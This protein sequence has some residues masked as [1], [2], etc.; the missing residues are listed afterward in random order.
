MEK[1]IRTAIQEL[2]A[3]KTAPVMFFMGSETFFLDEAIQIIENNILTEDEKAFNQNVVY[4]PEANVEM[5]ISIARS[6]PMMAQKR[7]LILKEAQSF[8][9][10]EKL[11]PYFKNPVESTIF[12]ILYRGKKLDKKK[13]FTKN[14]IASPKILVASSDPLNENELVSFISS[15]G[16]E[17]GLRI[18]PKASYALKELLGDNLDKITREI[19]KIALS[20]PKGAEVQLQEVAEQVGMS[21]EYNV[22]EL[23]SVIASGNKSKVYRMIMHMNRNPNQ[24]PFPLIISG[25]YSF[26]ARLLSFYGARVE[27]ELRK[28]RNEPQLDPYR[29]ARV[30]DKNDMNMALQR[31]SS[32]KTIRNLLI[33][34]EYDVKFKGVQNESGTPQTSLL[35]E[36]IFKLMQ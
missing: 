14:L 20:L 4:G 26:F 6:Y 24:Y 32:E 10:L 7:V 3:G 11:E 29:E 28:K 34:S 18:H 22:F 30:F 33:L 15:F 5:L 16:A 36:L 25:L 21:R 13:T 19:R 2:Q 17:L 9:D 1:N 35:K 31:F 12:A 8:R 27:N 23:P